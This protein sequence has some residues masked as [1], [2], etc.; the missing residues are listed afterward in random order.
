MKINIGIADDHQLFL[1]SL[2]LLVS[3]FAGFHIVAEAMN[4][5]EMLD[6]L[7]Q[8]PALPDILLLDVNM[9]VMDGARA[10]EAVLKLYPTVKVVA[11]SMKD[12]DATIIEMLKAGCCAYLL[13]DI[14]PTE[15]EKAL[16]EIYTTGQYNNDAS[17]VNYRRLLLQ[18]EQ[19]QTLTEREREFLHLACSDLTY[20]AIAAKMNVTERTVDGYREI[21]FNK[22]NVQSRTGM[23]LEALRRQLVTL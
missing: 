4:G 2:S 3:G 11:L 13:K 10:T 22:L 16:T 20:K 6:K 1:K 5:R 8:L 23:V 21:L 19:K 9:P 14:H 17:N 15:L 12:N 18:S 7:A